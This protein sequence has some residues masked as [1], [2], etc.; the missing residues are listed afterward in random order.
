MSGRWRP[1]SRP[2]VIAHRGASGI[3]PEHCL[4]GY[5]LAIEQG[6]DVIEPDLV[7]SADGVLYARHDL[8]LARSTDIARRPEFAGYR[9]LGADG[10]EDWWIEDLSSAQVD[11]LCAIQPWPLRP[12]DRDG[13]YRVPRFSAV[14]DLLRM[15]RQRRERPLLVYP[16]LKHPR[17]FL[18]RG[19]DVVEL[20]AGD[21]ERA[22]LTGR[23]APVLVQCFDRDCL[24]QVRERLDVRVVQLSI[25]L[26]ALDGS[27][28]DGYG[29]SRQA[30]STPAG[31]DFIVAAHALDRVVHAWTFRDDQPL[32]NLAPVDECAAA[33][34]QGC[35]GLFSDFPATAIAARSRLRADA[36]APVRVVNVVGAAIDA[37]LPAL[38]DLRIRVFREW[39]YLYDGD[40][41]YEARYLQTYS[42]SPHSLFVLALAGDEVVGCATGIPLRDASAECQAPFL[43]AGMDLQS[44]YYFGES[45]LDRRYR[46]TGLGHR[47]FDAR[48]AHA[49]SFPG[50]RYTAFCA[51]QRAADDPRRPPLARPLDAF[52]QAR[53]YTRHGELVTRFVWKELDAEEPVA[54]T[55]AFWM[56]EWPP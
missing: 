3:L 37:Y 14:L 46:G 52:W 22:G 39:P 35:D 18:A 53:G 28:V 13:V 19:I 43:A 9:R 11:S 23:D 17:H 30:L 4:P 50:L 49:R 38:A 24:D 16:E 2:W 40:V 44:V 20:L 7:A 42:R 26:P 33:F 32:G 56:R 47:F 36:R 31:G 51:V 41:E 6:A 25:D 10:S 45:V 5:A 1:Y 54:N 34:A 21:L 15:E 27:P 12:H 48:E 55:M 8:G 29:V